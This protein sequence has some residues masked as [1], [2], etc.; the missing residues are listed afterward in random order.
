MAVNTR[1]LRDDQKEMTRLRFV[2]T[3]KKLFISQGYVRTSADQI[4]SEAG[5]SRATFYL[6]YTGKP[7]LLA[8]IF[9]A[10]HVAPL[11]KLIERLGAAGPGDLKALN[12][13]IRAYA[14]HYRKTKALMRAWMQAQTQEGAELH[15]LSDNL[16]QE[17]I[18]AIAEQVAAANHA[19]TP[20]TPGEARLRAMMMFA[21][22]ERYCYYVHIRHK[23]YDEERALE[24]ITTSWAHLIRLEN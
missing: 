22:L 1:S 12:E 17:I 5:T 8:E 7:A 10:E 3:G 14:A 2:S 19:L 20:I 11:M 18:N 4:A 16:L 9:Q 13:W 6:H 21:E 24:L 23:E 15:A